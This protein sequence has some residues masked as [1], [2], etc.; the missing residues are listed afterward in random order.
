VEIHVSMNSLRLLN[1][2]KSVLKLGIDSMLS[3]CHTIVMEPPGIPD[4]PLSRFSLSIFRLNG[5][6]MWHGDRITRSMGQSSARWQV[7]GRVGDQPQTVAQMARDMGHARQ[8]VQR[9]ADVLAKEG[10]VV[11]KDNPA[12]QRARLLELTPQGAEILAEIYAQSEEW[13]RHMLTKLD[14]MQLAE[15]SD[16]LEKVAHILETDE[17]Q[18]SPTEIKGERGV[19]AWDR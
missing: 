8:S 5:L 19:N 14:A 13:S 9:L 12:D 1:K 18:N 4:D 10:L 3:K 16:A 15:I 11:Y 2:S 7:L 17:K 6:L